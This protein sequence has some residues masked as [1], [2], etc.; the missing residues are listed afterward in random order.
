MRINEHGVS[1]H[2]PAVYLV[3]TTEATPLTVG[4]FVQL[5]GRDSAG[6]L[7]VRRAKPNTTTPQM[8]AFG[9]VV[10]TFDKMYVVAPMG[11]EYSGKDFVVGE[12]YVVGSDSRPA[13]VTGDPTSPANAKPIQP[14]GI[15]VD[16]KLIVPLNAGASSAAVRQPTIKTGTATLASGVAV[17]NEALA[18]ANTRIFLTRKS[19]TGAIGV[20]LTALG[21]GPTTSFEIRSLKAD[22]TTETSEGASVISWL[23]IDP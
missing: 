4:E 22:G 14:I 7:S 5:M 9:H 1:R 23:M 16:T 12:L 17:V 13:R 19:H 18:S 6:N 11:S 8:P 2:Y 20:E 15:A 21:T 10:A 3:S